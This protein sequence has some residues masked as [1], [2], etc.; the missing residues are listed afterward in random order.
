MS[1][2]D[3]ALRSR[4]WLEEQLAQ[5]ANLRNASPRDPSFKHWRQHTLT[6]LQR[7]WPRHASRS[8]R[9]RRIAFSPASARTDGQTLRDWFARGCAEAADCLGELLVEID[10]VGVPEPGE[11]S[12]PAPFAGAGHEDD[13]PVLE[14]P[15]GQAGRTLDTGDV[16]ENMRDLGGMAAPAAPAA[17]DEP[18]GPSGEAAAP[19]PP[20]LKVELKRP[21]AAAPPG[22]PVAPTRVPAE[23]DPQSHPPIAPSP[24]AAPPASA[25]SASA[26]SAS[27]SSASSP[28]APASSASAPSASASSASTPSAPA[29]GAGKPT[30]RSTRARKPAT[31]TRLKEM[32]GLN[33]MGHAESQESAQAPPDATPPATSAPAASARPSASAPTPAPAPTPAGGQ[34]AFDTDAFARASGDL[35]A[36]SP[37]FALQGKPV[38]RT[39]DA[40]EFIDPDAVALATLAADLGRLGVPEAARSDLRVALLAV[41]A[42]I[43]AAKPE[44]VTMQGLVSAAMA[45][46]EL[47]RRLMPILLPWLPRA[48]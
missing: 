19:T 14:L 32:L 15:A 23:P 43:E 36:N 29:P 5:L 21:V 38:L 12:G 42:Q 35:L 33:D 28:S 4:G 39:S 25:S 18:L 16:G 11:A 26:P 7:I 40:T 41:A 31:K 46:P 48:A 3:D 45:H 9:F 20:R 2:A 10:A 13:F 30:A 34:G 27:A 47:A 17:P 22:A 44:W 8:E 37:L 6:V 1:G 24:P